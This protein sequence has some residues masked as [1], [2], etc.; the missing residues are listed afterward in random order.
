MIV[1]ECDLT[2]SL[3]DGTTGESLKTYVAAV[4][5]MAS[6]LAAQDSAEGK[7]TNAL[8]NEFGDNVCARMRDGYKGTG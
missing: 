1:Q 8:L 2:I 4:R 3:K 6:W 5:F 7:D